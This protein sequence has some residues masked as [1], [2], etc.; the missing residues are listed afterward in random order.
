MDDAA[1]SLD[2]LDDMGRALRH[3]IRIDRRAMG[4][5]Y[6]GDIR[7]ILDRDRQPAQYAPLARRQSLD[8]LR[9]FSRPVETERWQSIDLPIDCVDP[10]LQR[11]Q[12]PS[13]ADIA[14]VQPVENLTRR[15]V[16]Q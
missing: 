9:M 2:P 16:D 13:M 12:H 10:G 14:P 4:R 5:A 8:R 15:L 7:E 11:F 1:P 3:M 6:A